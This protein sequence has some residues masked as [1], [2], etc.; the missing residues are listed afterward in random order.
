MKS[1]QV[2]LHYSN[3]ITETVTVQCLTTRDIVDK[4]KTMAGIKG[5]TGEVTDIHIKLLD[6]RP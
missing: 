4:A 2:T 3:N 1:Y 5:V 6:K